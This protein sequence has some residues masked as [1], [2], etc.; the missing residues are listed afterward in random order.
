MIT[1]DIDIAFDYGNRLIV[2]KN[3]KIVEIIQNTIK[4]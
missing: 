1:H 4:I 2:L 3:G